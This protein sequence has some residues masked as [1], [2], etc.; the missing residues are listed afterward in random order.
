LPMT[1]QDALIILN[2]VPGMGSIRIRQLI[3]HFGSAR[4]VLSLSK[5]HFCQEKVLPENAITKIVEFPQDKFLKNE[6]N[7][8]NGHQVEVITFF[9]EEY[10]SHLKN[11]YQAP[12]VL[13][14]KGQLSKVNELSIAIVGSRRASFY[15]LTM[16]ESLAAQLAEKGL[17]IVSGMAR[18]ID[19][20]AHKGALKSGGST[21]A[22]L[23]CGLSHI[24]PPE[25]KDLFS[26][27][28]K[29][30]VVLSEFPMDI[31]P[32][33]KNFPRRNR[34]ISGLALGVLVVEATK[35]SGALIT[36]RFAL[37][38]GR[39]VFAI[40]GLV[41]RPQSQGTHR[42]IQ[43]GAELVS[44][45]DDILEEINF[46]C[47]DILAHYQDKDRSLT[48][49]SKRPLSELQREILVQFKEKPVHIDHLL[50][51][52]VDMRGKITNSLLQLEMNNLIKQLPGKFYV[53]V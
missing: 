16:A 46:Q 1:E 52:G 32:A 21:M 28:V 3:K 33:A 7:L 30:G 22:V 8:M 4:N 41:G 40:P 42:L 44:H 50:S 25:N 17:C 24:Y 48:Q 12:I 38:Q 47:K 6:Y 18:G 53:R 9:D 37:E 10:P 14:H 39:E 51:C 2:A 29:E 43:E 23:G 45:I 19:S 11:I 20:A 49:D 15:G 5:S 36:S 13:Y 34:I 31:P 35:N 26:A 27:I